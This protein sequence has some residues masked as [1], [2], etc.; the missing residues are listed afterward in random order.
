[1]GVAVGVG[2]VVALVRWGCGVVLVGG[3]AAALGVGMGANIVERLRVVDTGRM[4]DQERK[5][6]YGNA[7]VASLRPHTWGVIGVPENVCY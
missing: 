3:C 6:E 4:I 2:T 5:A 1:M 7:R